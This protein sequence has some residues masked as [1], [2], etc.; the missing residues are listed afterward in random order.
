MAAQPTQNLLI[1]A[2][3][4][5]LGIA[6]G[7]FYYSSYVVPA[8]VPVLPPPIAQTDDLKAFE[9]LQ[10][11]FSILTNKKFQTL[12]IFGESPVNPGATGKKDLFFPL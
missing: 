8:L 5:L 10:M 1:L 11:D 9:G 4:I 12:Q 3:I 7:Y 2:L 6:L